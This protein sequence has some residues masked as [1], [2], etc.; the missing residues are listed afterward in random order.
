M[1]RIKLLRLSF[2]AGVYTFRHSDALT[3]KWKLITS[4][5]VARAYHSDLNPFINSGVRN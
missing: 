4:Y 2:V 3:L 1:T 5:R